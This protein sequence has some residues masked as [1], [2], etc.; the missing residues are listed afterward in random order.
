[1]ARI[2]RIR[3][4][5]GPFQA[6]QRLLVE[7]TTVSFGPLLERRMERFRNVFQ[8]DGRHGGTVMDAKWMSM[9]TRYGNPACSEKATKNVN[10]KNL[11]FSRD[12]TWIG[13]GDNSVEESV[14]LCHS[15]HRNTRLFGNPEPQLVKL[16][17]NWSNFLNHPGCFR[18]KK[19]T[20]SSG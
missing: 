7:R 17:Q 9:G 18:V 19:Q 1:M 10:A 15:Q 3:P 14:F 5:H 4:L 20:Q 6:K 8:R 16:V 11:L 13:A 12:G 2:V